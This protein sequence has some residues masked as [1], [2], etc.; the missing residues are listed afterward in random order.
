[1]QKTYSFEFFVSY[2]LE[3]PGLDFPHYPQIASRDVFLCQ[4]FP[5]LIAFHAARKIFGIPGGKGRIFN[6]DESM[7][8]RYHPHQKSWT[9]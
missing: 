2:G 3:E 7:M 5:S 4:S 1:M 9:L 6:Y 8:Y